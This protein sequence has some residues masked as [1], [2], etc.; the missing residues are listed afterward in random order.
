[1]E[2][3]FSSANFWLQGEGAVR[4]SVSRAAAAHLEGGD[5]HFPMKMWVQ[6]CSLVWKVSTPSRSGAGAGV[7][8]TILTV[9]GSPASEAWRRKLW[10]ISAGT[11]ASVSASAWTWHSVSLVYCTVYCV[12]CN[13][14]YCTVPGVLRQKLCQN[15]RHGRR[16]VLAHQLGARLA[17]EVRLLQ[18]Q[19]GLRYNNY[20]WSF[21]F[22]FSTKHLLKEPQC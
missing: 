8:T 18:T 4:L 13:V 16:A 10:K 2:A 19:A 14:M 15:P 3:S 12:Y 20:L 11:L 6:P 17:E 1:M 22:S 9:T 7:S 5:T 21:M